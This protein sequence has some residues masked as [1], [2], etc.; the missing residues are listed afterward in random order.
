MHYFCSYLG[1]QETDYCQTDYKSKGRDDSISSHPVIWC[2]LLLTVSVCTLQNKYRLCSL[3][4]KE[5][6]IGGGSFRLLYQY[7]SLIP[8]M[9]K[10]VK[11]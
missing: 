6:H 3:N 4:R 8:E 2:L 9:F 7:C 10:I 1:N 5:N 11:D